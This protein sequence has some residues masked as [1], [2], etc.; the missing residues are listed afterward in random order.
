M[1]DGPENPMTPRR[2]TAY[3]LITL[4]T[5]GV[6]GSIAFR[7]VSVELRL[8]PRFGIRSLAAIALPIVAGGYAFAAHRSALRGLRD[9]PAAIRFAASLIAGALILASV[10]FFLLL[11]P[12]LAAELWIG[13]CLALLVFASDTVPGVALGEPPARARWPFV[14]HCG[15]AAGMLLYAAVYGVPRFPG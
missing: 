2:R 12:V 5:L 8:G 9:L 7:F 13:S 4:V 14:P 6:L 11:Y 10:R 3:A 1:D 15:L